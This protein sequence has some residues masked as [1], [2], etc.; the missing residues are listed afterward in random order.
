[1]K[2]AKL[3]SQLMD[4]LKYFKQLHGYWQQRELVDESI[5]TLY[6]ETSLKDIIDQYSAHGD[7]WIEG[8]SVEDHDGFKE[9]RL[10]IFKK[11]KQTDQEYFDSVCEVLG[12][13][14]QHEYNQYLRLAQKYGVR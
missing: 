4:C 7:V 5:D 6:Q 8:Y 13:Y 12:G 1:M 10:H 2:D 11:R 3:R 14:D 9:C